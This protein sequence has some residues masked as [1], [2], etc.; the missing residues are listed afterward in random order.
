[1]VHL[2][3]L[4]KLS[5]S[6]LIHTEFTDPWRKGH[7]AMP[8]CPAWAH[9][10]EWSSRTHTHI[11]WSP[12]TIHSKKRREELFSSRRMM[13][14]LID[15]V[16]LYDDPVTVNWRGVYSEWEGRRD[17][18]ESA[19]EWRGGG[20]GG[21]FLRAWWCHLNPSI[22]MVLCCPFK[23]WENVPLSATA[24]VCVCVCVMCLWECVPVLRENKAWTKKQCHSKYSLKMREGERGKEKGMWERW[25]GKIRHGWVFIEMLRAGCSFIQMLVYY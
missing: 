2:S 18:W 16:F 7:C 23:A 20:V 19:C 6:S 4:R 11:P 24:S 21:L 1:M 9:P 12:L 3:A 25:K 15:L 8:W 13:Q 10:T 14:G 17:A 5:M 22:R